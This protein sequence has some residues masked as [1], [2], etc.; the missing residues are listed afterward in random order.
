VGCIG[1]SPIGVPLL[2]SSRQGDHVFFSNSWS[3]LPISWCFLGFPS[4][5]VENLGFHLGLDLY[6]IGSQPSQ[7]MVS[8]SL[9]CH[10]C[11]STW[12]FC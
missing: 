10:I 1:S 3:F 7:A 5:C 11:T 9:T 6:A 12:D 8:F 4:L 2:A